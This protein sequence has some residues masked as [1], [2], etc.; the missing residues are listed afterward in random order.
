MGEILMRS[1]ADRCESRE[2]HRRADFP[3]ADPLLGG[4]AHI[5]C[6]QGDGAAFY[7]KASGEKPCRRE[8]ISKCDG[9]GI[10]VE[11][12]SEDVFFGTPG[13]SKI[14]TEKAVVSNP[15]LCW[16]CNWCRSSAWGHPLAIPL[17]MHIPYKEMPD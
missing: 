15:E 17:C 10:C 3:A 11:L 16:H 6:R 8:L 5:V 12:C 4:K 13:F 1:A 2:L 9:C 7:W 14:H